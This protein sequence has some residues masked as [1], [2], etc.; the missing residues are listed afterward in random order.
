MILA[1]FIL[2]VASLRGA[3]DDLELLHTAK[4]FERSDEHRDM[5]AA[6]EQSELGQQ[7]LEQYGPEKAKVVLRAQVAEYLLA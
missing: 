5:L 1:G 7:I 3:N 6:W 2:L 4:A